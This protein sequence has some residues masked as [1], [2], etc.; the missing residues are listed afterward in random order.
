MRW[1]S[2]FQ[3]GHD[4]SFVLEGD[5]L[6]A[7]NRAAG[8]LFGCPP[9]ELVGLSLSDLFAPGQLV[10]SSAPEAIGTWAAGAR[11]GEVRRLQLCGRRRDGCEFD[12][13]F[14]LTPLQG[15]ERQVLASVREFGVAD[16]PAGGTGR[17]LSGRTAEDHYRTLVS[18]FP[19]GAL[20]LFDTDLRLMVA[21]S[22]VLVSAGFPKESLE[23]RSL[24][25]LLPAKTFRLVE[26]HL[27]GALAGQ[28][29]VLEVPFGGRV[30]SVHVRPARD[31]AGEIVAGM[32]VV[33]D[34]TARKKEEDNLRYLSAHDPLT[35]LFNRLYFEEEMARLAKGRHFPVSIVSAD[36]DGL[37]SVN[38]RLGH[39]AGDDLLRQAAEVLQVSFRPGD[40]VARI[41]G[42]EFA[43]LLPGAN[44]AAGETVLARVRR[45]ENAYVAPDDR[46][47]VHF[48]LGLA[49]AE[50]GESLA[51]TLRLADSRMYRDKLEH[52]KKP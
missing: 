23:G 42:D 39:A 22:A 37:K 8:K 18:N 13:E 47:A 34:V 25:A 16:H 43:V 30:Y 50:E 4:P 38:D 52:A 9:E 44:A 32:A 14:C 21:E 45:N 10:G 31:P 41:G 20:V 48:S 11:A 26:P 35:S 36:V 5:Q 46:P 40:V 7:A 33:Q 12:A 27:R 1:E 6:V 28:A 29:S 19:E 2:V 3:S 51:E 49:T 15:N 17:G 24:A